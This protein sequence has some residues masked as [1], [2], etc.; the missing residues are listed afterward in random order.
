[1][2][3]GVTNPAVHPT[4]LT[5]AIPAAAPGPRRNAVGSAQ[6]GPRHPQIPTAAI[7]SVTTA[8]GVFGQ[9]AVAAMPAL[10]IAA[11]SA[12]CQCRS[13]VRSECRPIITIVTAP[14]Q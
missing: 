5:T 8:Q 6:N 1:M 10:A 11:Q 12:T 13:P 2:T 9:S 4:E 3:S 7:D 14:T